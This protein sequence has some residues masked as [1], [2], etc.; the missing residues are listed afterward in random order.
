MSLVNNPNPAFLMKLTEKE[1]DLHDLRFDWIVARNVVSVS[2]LKNRDFI[3]N[4]FDS[5][6]YLSLSKQYLYTLLFSSSE[7]KG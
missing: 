4:A 5:F 1:K 6:T 3:N 2:L 7:I